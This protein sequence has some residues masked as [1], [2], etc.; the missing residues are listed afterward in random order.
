MSKVFG[1]LSEVLTKALNAV[2]SFARGFNE[3]T[4]NLFDGAKKT[5]TIF[6]IAFVAAC[7]LLSFFLKRRK[8][9]ILS[10]SIYV[11]NAIYM[12]LPFEIG[13][14]YGNNVFVFLGAV[15]AVFVLL[16]SSITKG[17]YGGSTS[18]YAG[19]IKMILLSFITLGFLVSSALNFVTD[20]DILSNI[21]LVDKIFSGDISRAVWAILPLAGFLF[22]RH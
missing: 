14:N 8:I 6:I 19:R 16:N 4:G 9:I 2:I 3:K 18:D 17:V 21:K 10:V 7:A 5:D 1:V 15:V 12:A 13:M 22:L 20:I 11:V